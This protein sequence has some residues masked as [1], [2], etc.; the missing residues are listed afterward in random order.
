MLK[1]SLSVLLAV[2]TAVSC[3]VICASAADGG[4]EEPVK[5]DS[6]YYVGQ[7]IK[8]GDKITSVHETCETLTVSYSVSSTDAENVTSALQKKYASE[9]YIGVVSFRDVIASFT[10]GETY[11]GVYT[12]KDKG[13]EVDEMEVDN[14]SYKSALDIYNGLTK[15]EQKAL[16]KQLKKQKQEFA[17]SI[18]YEYAKATYYQYTT[19][20]SWKVVFVN[21]TENALTI[22]L[23]AV[24]ETREPTGGEAFVEK[25]YSKW[26]AFLDVLGNV[27]LKTTPK[28]LAFWAKILGNK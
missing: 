12:V 6:G 24:Y 14:G 7:I 5:T 11:A 13:D 22:S 19:I 26:L 9:N 8:P 25:L 18:D 21:E 4:A 27:L 28:L 23:Q 1:K 17:L 10:S 2:L 3:M 16:D 15:D 20:T